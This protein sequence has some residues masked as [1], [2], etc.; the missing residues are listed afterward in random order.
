M[1]I[2][3]AYIQDVIRQQQNSFRREKLVNPPPKTVLNRKAI[4]KF[5][6]NKK[7]V[8]WGVNPVEYIA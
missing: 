8:W 5:H 3:A 4:G 2:S 7:E 6:E 1:D